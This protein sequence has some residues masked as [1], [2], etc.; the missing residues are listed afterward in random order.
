MKNSRARLFPDQFLAVELHPKTPCRTNEGATGGCP[1]G[2]YAPLAVASG[3]FDQMKAW[4]SSRLD[5]LNLLSTAAPPDRDLSCFCSLYH[6]VPE[7]NGLQ[8]H[9]KINTD[10]IKSRPL[11]P[12]LVSIV[13]WTSSAAKKRTCSRVKQP[14][15]RGF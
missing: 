6:D 11:I 9:L 7:T 8:Y 14:L 15:P 5:E 10:H 12:A 1:M 4:E 2:P 13:F 3:G